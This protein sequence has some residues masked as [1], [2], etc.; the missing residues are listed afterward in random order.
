[1]GSVYPRGKRL[2]I[3]YKTETG[4]KK[5]VPSSYVVGQEVLARE[6]L[7]KLEDRVQARLSVSGDGKPTVAVYGEK[8]IK[9]RIARGFDMDVDA[10]RLRN[11]VFP[12][13]GDLPLGDV[14]PR[15]IRDM[16]YLLEQ[17]K[18]TRHDR[19]GNV[20]K[21]EKI[22]PRTIKNIFGVLRAMCRSAVI[23]ELIVTTP[24]MVER[25]DMPKRAD[26]DPAW[27]REAVFSRE[28]IELLI[29]DE[30]VPED[31]RVFYSVLFIGGVRFGECAA[32]RMRH[33]DPSVKPLGR[34]VVA[35]SY[36]VKTKAEKSTKTD[37]IREVPVHPTLA[38]VLAAWKLGGWERMMGRA[39]TAEDLLVPSRLGKNRSVNH[40]LK[41]FHQDL[42]RLGMRIRR[43]HDLR[44][45]F[46]SL[47]RGAE[48]S[49]D[50]LKWI[51]HGKSSSVMD[52]YTTPPWESLCGVILR[53]K[54]SLLEGKVLAL[55]A[56]VTDGELPS[57]GYIGATVENAQ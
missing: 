40:M 13:L 8:W 52:D 51:T 22:A 17:K 55:P 57:S 10:A 30:R 7:K 18:V 29:S 42:E 33:Y 50:L 6:A 4:R 48:V 20:V 14:R 15:H 26:K 31:R 47:T 12:I 43:Q 34:L 2:W 56:G 21:Q 24:C 54:V 9:K 28:E 11:H 3:K 23:D 38:K 39:P 16:L 32:L 37:V 25:E 27:R 1:M 46:I 44:R 49:A 45:T 35:R 5:C 53:L 41:R 19:K 36:N